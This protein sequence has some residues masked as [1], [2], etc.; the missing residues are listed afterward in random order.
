[1]CCDLVLKQ[2]KLIWVCPAVYTLLLVQLSNSVNKVSMSSSLHTDI[3]GTS[4]AQTAL[5]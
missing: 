5:R 2:G 3:I 4:K 1:M